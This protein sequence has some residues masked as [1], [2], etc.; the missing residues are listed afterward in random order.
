MYVRRA[1]SVCVRAY[2]VCMRVLRYSVC[3]SVFG[4]FR[5]YWLVGGVQ[6]IFQFHVRTTI[7]LIIRVLH[8]LRHRRLR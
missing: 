4:I 5:V 7:L 3:L 6:F 8:L 1:M 2:D